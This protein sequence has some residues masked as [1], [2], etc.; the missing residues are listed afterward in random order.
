MRRSSYGKYK[1]LQGAIAGKVSAPSFALFNIMAIIGHL[2]TAASV[3]SGAFAAQWLGETKTEGNT[4]Y[5]CKC[6]SDNACWPSQ[7]DW[8][9]LNTTVGGALLNALPPAAPCHYTM[10]GTKTY[11]AAECETV[12]ALY[13]D[14]TWT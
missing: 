10:N 13:T 9:A 6:Y 8:N 2:L 11:N 3:F 12:N 1:G 14:E 5:Q 4:T 7:A